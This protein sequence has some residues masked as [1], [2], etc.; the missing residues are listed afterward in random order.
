[1]KTVSVREAQHNLAKLLRE[2]R[3]GRTVEILRRKVPVARIVPIGSGGSADVVVDWSDHAA[4][5]AEVWGQSSVAGVDSVLSDLRG[6][7]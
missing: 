1:M 2:V 5:M 6:G 3:G 4:R 7:E